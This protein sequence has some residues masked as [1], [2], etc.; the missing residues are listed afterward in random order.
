MVIIEKDTTI[1]MANTEFER[2]TGHAK[3]EI[4]GKMSWTS[5][6]V[7][8]DLEKMVEYHYERREK[9][10]SAPRNYEFRLTD[11]EGKVKNI[12]LTIGMLPDKIK[13]VASLLDVTARKQA[14]RERLEANA[15][16][17][18]LEKLAS[19]GTMAAGIAHEVAQPL[20]AIKVMVDGTLYW[21]K[22]G[23]EPQMPKVLE[24]LNKISSQIGRID[25][26]I[27][28]VQSFVRLQEHPKDPCDLNNALENALRIIGRQLDAHGIEVHKNL[29]NELPTVWAIENRLEEVVINLLTNAMQSLE[30][31]SRDTKEIT[32]QTMLKD[33]VILEIS[34]NGPGVSE[35]IRGMI[36]EPLF[37]TKLDGNNM[38][39]GL[40][41]VSSIIASSGGKIE[42]FT[43][44]QGGATFRVCFP[45]G[46]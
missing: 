17:A 42:V 7:K 11:K 1:S 41:I 36:F 13:S 12:H 33:R 22:R 28:R 27:K 16:V 21:H 10:E 15:Q 3:E 31:V 30:T 8:E 9:G 32:C 35:E 4:E 25:D 18:R 20:N 44:E 2:L 19:L 23:K 45:P 5:M 14:E 29:S 24:N 39:L 46:Q 6:V 26:I 43:N 38:G 37:T 40:T 34:D